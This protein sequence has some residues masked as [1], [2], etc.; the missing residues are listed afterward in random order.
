MPDKIEIT[1]IEI[2]INDKKVTLSTEDAWQLKRELDKL[3]HT[4]S[5]PCPCPWP[6]EPISPYVPYVPYAEPYITWDSGTN[7]AGGFSCETVDSETV[8]LVNT[9]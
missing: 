6:V 3:L 7:S 5:L 2:K 1:G 8:G 4:Q 9:F